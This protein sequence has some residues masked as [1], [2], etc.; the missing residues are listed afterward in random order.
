MSHHQS[1]VETQAPAPPA[2]TCSASCPQLVSAT[3]SHPLAQAGE[4]EVLLDTSLSFTPTFHSQSLASAVGSP[5]SLPIPSSFSLS[6]AWLQPSLA[7]ALNLDH[8]DGLLNRSPD[9]SV[10]ARLHFMFHTI[11]RVI[12]ER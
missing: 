9:V 8:S 11:V 1:Q 6:T 7:S 5:D 2:G 10:L 12:F 4:L 3:T